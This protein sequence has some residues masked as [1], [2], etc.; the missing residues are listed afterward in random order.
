MESFGEYLRREREM[1][2]VTLAEIAQATKISL[3]ALEALEAGRYEDVGAEIFIRGF[4][5]H[6]ARYLGLDPEEVV[7][8]YQESLGPKPNE[9][10]PER[11]E[12]G[13][14]AIHL[15]W[16]KWVVAGMA[17]VMAMLILVWPSSQTPP[18]EIS[19]AASLPAPVTMPIALVPVTASTVPTSPSLQPATFD[20]LVRAESTS[21]VKA[22]IDGGQ[23]VER[24]LG[25]GQ[26]WLLRGQKKI[27]FLTGNA[28]G[29][30]LW[31]NGRELA[32]L[33]PAGRVRKRVFTSEEAAIR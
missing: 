11:P 20:L 25:P 4:L 3:H 7:M 14:V 28:G 5:R 16:L 9:E 33:G 26:E 32:P 2:G 31:L 15:P 22:S 13:W 29:V 12:K 30:K 19:T 18:R 24:E 1:R 8:R 27:E 10:K 21:Y 17:V 23:A 6:Y